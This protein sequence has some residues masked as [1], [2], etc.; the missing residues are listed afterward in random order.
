[1]IGLVVD[2]T[3]RRQAERALRDSE[4]RLRTVFDSVSD[5]LV[6]YDIAAGT[7]IDAN[8]CAL[9]MFGY[10]RDELMKLDLRVLLAGVAPYTHEDAMPVLKA[11]ASGTA[12]TVEWSCVAKDGHGLWIEVSL[13][14]AQFSG[15]AVLLATARDV[16]DRRRSNEQV[17]YMARHDGLT[18]LANRTVFVEALQQ[19]IERAKRGAESFA[20]LYLDLDHFKDVNDTLGHP[21]GDLLLCSLADRLRS[22]IRGTDTAARFG[23]DEFAIIMP[24][25]SE[26]LDVTALADKLLQSISIPYNIQG[27]EIRSGAS[28]GIAIYGPDA[29]TAEALLSQADVALYRA[30]AEGRG[31]CRFFTDDMDAEVNTR[32]QLAAELREAIV[33]GQL[34]LDYQP[35]IDVDTGRIIGVEA[36]ARWHHPTRGLVL[37]DVFVPVAEH[38]GII[39]ALGRWALQAACRQMKQWI[40]A[41]IAPPLIAVNVSGLQ[42]KTPFELEHEIAAIL[43]ETGVPAQ[44]LELELTESVLMDVSR[45]HNTMLQ[46]LRRCGHRIAID[47]FGSGYSSLEYLARFPVD[48]IKI[49]QGF[50]VGLMSSSSN[51]VI[52]KAAIGLAHDLNLDVVVEGVETVEQLDLIRSWGCR[53][54]QG[55][56]F[57]KSLAAGEVTALLR[58]GQISPAPLSV[59]DAAGARIPQ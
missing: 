11:A 18:G 16:T 32:V 46:R 50:I 39:V 30:K 44:R 1:L 45:D 26:P 27:R 38:A 48:R 4:E 13:R 10:T 34:S 36:L 7:I 42:F 37:P 51:R 47:D 35:Q 58:I 33:D 5:A 3:E 2:I 31:T 52:V 14:K 23:G 56:Y 28:V 59:K 24:G 15:R 29:P 53:K 49:A 43:T 25:I 6:V 41:D 8:P 19:A 17:T 20:V 40:D 22:T 57:S 12:L 54:V 21:I 9:E 55:Y